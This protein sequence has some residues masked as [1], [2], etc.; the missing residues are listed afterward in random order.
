MFESFIYVP[1]SKPMKADV[2]LYKTTFFNII[3]NI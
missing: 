2:T 1:P 3:E